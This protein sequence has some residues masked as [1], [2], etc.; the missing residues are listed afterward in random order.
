MLIDLKT[1]EELKAL[2]HDADRYLA[3]EEPKCLFRLGDIIRW[4]D[5]L[6]Q[7]TG[8]GLAGHAHLDNKTILFNS[9]QHKASLLWRAI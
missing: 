1:R 6:R 8:I 9:D 5:T 3:D 2:Y 7:V 4:N